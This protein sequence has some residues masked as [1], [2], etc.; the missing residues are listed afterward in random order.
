MFSKIIVGIFIVAIVSAAVTT[1]PSSQDQK[2]NL[3]KK[4]KL[5]SISEFQKQLILG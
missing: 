5:E 2:V 4:K 3:F 1:V